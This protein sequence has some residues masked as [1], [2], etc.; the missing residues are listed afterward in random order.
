MR[1]PPLARIAALAAP[2]PDAEPVTIAHKPS[3]DIRISFLC[4]WQIVFLAKPLFAAIYHIAR[5]NACK[6]AKLRCAELMPAPLHVTLASLLQGG[7]CCP[8]R[9][10]CGHQ[11]LSWLWLFLIMRCKKT[12]HPK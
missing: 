4:S 8:C 10:P 12:P 3:P 2:R 9:E 11:R 1:A 7:S 6:P 5:G